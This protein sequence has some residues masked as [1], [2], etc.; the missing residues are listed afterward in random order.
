M[1]SGDV[2]TRRRP[3]EHPFRE[4]HPTLHAHAF[5]SSILSTPTL[6][7]EKKRDDGGRDR[8]AVKRK[9]LPSVLAIVPGSCR[10]RKGFKE[11]LSAQIRRQQ[12]TGGEKTSI[13]PHA[14]S[15]RMGL[16][17]SLAFVSALLQKTIDWKSD[18]L[19]WND[20]AHTRRAHARRERTARR[21]L[22][23]VASADVRAPRS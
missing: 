4:S 20:E 9:C 17:T 11:M 14:S 2:K 8:R 5:S 10:S 19:Y 6:R 3:I 13:G 22:P 23:I 15:H 18:P 21:L 16:A 7:T 12:A 1:P